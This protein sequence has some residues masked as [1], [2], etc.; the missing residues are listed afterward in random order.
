MVKFYT[1]CPERQGSDYDVIVFNSVLNEYC[2]SYYLDTQNMNN[3]LV[4][5][6]RESDDCDQSR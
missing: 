2:I 1:S 3:K 5:L 6:H 4:L